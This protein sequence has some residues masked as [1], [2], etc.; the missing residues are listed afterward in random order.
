MTPA[1]APES[2]RSA[3]CALEAAPA[4]V[5]VSVQTPEQSPRDAWTI[6]ATIVAD[7]GAPPQL[8]ATLG[9]HDLDVPEI[10]PRGSGYRLLAVR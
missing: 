5:G 10:A 3:A 2:I 6:E 8:L 4:V 9:E 1:L 7:A